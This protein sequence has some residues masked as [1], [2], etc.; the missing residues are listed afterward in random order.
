MDLLEELDKS[1][2][3]GDGAI[4]TLL[5]ERGISAGRCLEELCVAEPDIISRV[6]EDYL[7]AGARLIGTNSFGAN[8]VRLA[9]HGLE[10]RV[11]EINWQ[12]AQLAKQAAKGRNAYVAGSV[13]P[14]G[15]SADEAREQGINREEC[16]RTQIGALLDGGVNLIFLETFQDLEELLLAFRVKQS[17]HHC[18]AIC[19]LATNE[20]G[21]LPDGMSIE[22]AFAELARNDAEIFGMNCVNGPQATLRLV[23]RVAQ[24]VNPLAAFPNAGRPRYQEGRYVYETSPEYFAETIA[25]MAARGARILGGCC[26]TTPAH[27]AAAAK[28]LL[29]IKPEPFR[30]IAV[31]AP[32]LSEPAPAACEESLL[33]RI[34]AGKTV[35]MTELDPPKTLLLDKYFQAA[36]ALSAAGSDSIT[37]ADN[38]LAILRVSNLAIG[39]MLKQRGIMP[40]LH[41]SCRDRNLL[42]LQ[43]ELLG[44]AAMGVRHVLPLT[45]DP[46]KGGD[47][48]GASS[49][50]DV[51]SIKLIEIIR[52]LNE[53]FTQSGTDLKTSPGFVT[54]C[55]YNPNAKN[56]DAQ[57]SRLER[58]IAAGAQYVMTQP[59]FDT[60]LVEETH[61]RTSHLGVPV[62]IGVWPLLNGR[63]AK[64]L[65]NE[66]PGIRI[67]ENVLE[68]MEGTEGL[69]GRKRGVEIAKEVTRAVLDTYPCIYLITPFLAYELTVELAAFVRGR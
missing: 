12:A 9:R 55:T 69:E 51:N 17:L 54:G 24:S 57:V 31:S 47:H 50:Y 68:R 37:L 15:I 27:I 33:D 3:C 40:L 28:A 63:Q 41:V 6:H 61:R 26:G 42:G 23:E 53:G 35:I 48:P 62:F 19:S 32:V 20:N 5:M 1:P 56:L 30:P 67:P 60:A 25:Q 8:A 45:G 13:G 46:A 34:A 16:F 29:E 7:D 44:M 21:R 49:V 65:H 58:K 10:H 43:S 4:G 64:F 38:S 2:I 11:N 59:V 36:E 52:R 14:L 18:P 66:V 22:E 39:A